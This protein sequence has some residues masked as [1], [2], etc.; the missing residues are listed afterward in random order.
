MKRNTIKPAEL[1]EKMALKVSP[2]RV[3]NWLTGLRSPNVY[4]LHSMLQA[5]PDIDARQ[6]VADIAA[7]YKAKR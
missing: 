2:R 3:S 7:R 6:L 5:M 4:E 1:A